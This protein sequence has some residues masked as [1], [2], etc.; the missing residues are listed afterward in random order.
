M[1]L[2]QIFLITNEFGQ[3]NFN[4]KKPVQ[5][6]IIDNTK[7]IKELVQDIKD[8]IEDKICGTEVALNL[9][10]GTGKEHMAIIAAIIQS[11]L[12]FRLVVLTKDGVI[13]I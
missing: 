4:H 3:K 13:E 1:E 12:G 2:D 7:Q 11:G 10:S 9:I 6:I 8:A 5:F